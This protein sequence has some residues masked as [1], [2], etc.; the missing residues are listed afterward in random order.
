MSQRVAGSRLVD[1]GINFRF[2]DRTIRSG[3]G[4]DERQKKVKTEPNGGLDSKL[5]EGVGPPT[6]AIFSRHR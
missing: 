6:E 2:T 1:F 4:R 3:K 5:S